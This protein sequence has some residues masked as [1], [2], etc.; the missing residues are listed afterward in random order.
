MRGRPDYIRRME[1]RV[2]RRGRTRRV[3]HEA[4]YTPIVVSDGYELRTGVGRFAG[5]KFLALFAVVW[6]AF[7]SVFVVVGLVAGE[8]VMAAFGGLFV[9]VGLG[10]TTAFVKS[11]RVARAWGDPLVVIDRWP[12]RLGEEATAWFHRTAHRDG[13][14]ADTVA[15]RLVLRESATYRVGTDTRTATEDVVTVPLATEWRERNGTSGVHFTFRIPDEG[16]PTI[17]LPRN[18]VEWLLVFDTTEAG[19]P[20]TSALF[21]IRVAAEVAP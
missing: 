21:P 16:P 8:I 18:V 5:A 11:V 19:A 7:S 13:S 1:M 9:L 10:I 2:T 12:V 6:I 15:A 20:A 3:G 14:M 4:A 17:E